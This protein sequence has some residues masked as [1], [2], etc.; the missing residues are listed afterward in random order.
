MKYKQITGD[1]ALRLC[2]A[3]TGVLA[4]RFVESMTFQQAAEA[5]LFLA[6]EPDKL[7]ETCATSHKAHPEP[8][9]AKTS[10]RALDIDI[11]KVAG[12]K[13]AGK[14]TA[15]IADAM[16]VSAKQMG[17]WMYNNKAKVE[18]AMQQAKDA[19]EVAK[20]CCENEER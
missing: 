14:T 19:A 10:R 5:A 7:P 13:A 1:E 12:L 3:G 17:A 8:V 9:K 16:G 4:A 6:P 15:E 2:K 18:K 11:R 20:A